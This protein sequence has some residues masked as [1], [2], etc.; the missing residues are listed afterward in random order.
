MASVKSLDSSRR[1]LFSVKGHL[2]IA[3]HWWASAQ[4]GLG[5]WLL[6][7]FLGPL[8]LPFVILFGAGLT[9]LNGIFSSPM[10]HDNNLGA[11]KGRVIDIA[12]VQVY[13]PL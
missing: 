6:P 13:N 11:F 2:W 12:F 1:N 3:V 10:W 9:E 8:L 4:S 7:S 5:D